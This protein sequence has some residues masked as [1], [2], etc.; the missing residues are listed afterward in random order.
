MCRRLG[1]PDDT[2]AA[3]QAEG[4]SVLREGAVS[5]ATV[6]EST[7]DPQ[8]HVR[9]GLSDG[10]LTWPSVTSRSLCRGEAPARRCPDAATGP[11][12][13]SPSGNT[14]ATS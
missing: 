12:E 9:S 7:V 8:E 4:R 13:Q 1:W 14:R 3:L 11:F 2:G 6:T 5:G 10:I